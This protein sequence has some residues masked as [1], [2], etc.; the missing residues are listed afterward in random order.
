MLTF[1]GEITTPFNLFENSSYSLS[2]CDKPFL[3]IPLTEMRSK[4]Q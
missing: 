2:D 4:E 1:V 3:H